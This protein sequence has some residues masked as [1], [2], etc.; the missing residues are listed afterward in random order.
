MRLLHIITGLA[1]FMILFSSCLKKDLPALPLWNGTQI[2][3][4]YFEYRYLDTANVWQGAP[5]VAYK[6]LDATKTVDSAHATIS[7]SITVPPVSGSFD[8]AQRA[9]VSLDHLWCFMDLSTAASVVPVNDAPAQGFF[10]DFSK[11]QQYKVTAADGSSQVWT[12]TVVDF[13][14]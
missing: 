1:F 8:A 12:L 11:P 13:I 3:N 7:I 4:V 9:K 6:S 14:K 10:G 2:T 5:V